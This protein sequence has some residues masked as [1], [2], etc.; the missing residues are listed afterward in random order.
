MALWKMGICS[1][2]H[3]NFVHIYAFCSM[4]ILLILLELILKYIYIFCEPWLEENGF[5]VFG[6]WHR[7]LSFWD[8][9]VAEFNVSLGRKR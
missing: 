8:N 7:V 1:N 4:F 9:V 5:Y 6:G 2:V 3:K